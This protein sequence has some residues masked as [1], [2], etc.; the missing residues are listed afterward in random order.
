MD[1]TLSAFNK[2]WLALNLFTAEYKQLL[3]Q[4]LSPFWFV[5]DRLFTP[6][7]L[8]LSKEPIFLF[9]HSDMCI[10]SRLL[11]YWKNYTAFLWITE[12]LNNKIEKKEI[13]QNIKY[14]FWINVWEEAACLVHNHMCKSTFWFVHIT[15]QLYSYYLYRGNANAYLFANRILHS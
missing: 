11:I 8:R 14:L 12:H 15:N 2:Q 6:F 9:H 4:I 5:T 3:R 7:L 10:P 1:C 13:Q